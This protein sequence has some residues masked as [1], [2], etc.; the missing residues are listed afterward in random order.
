VGAGIATLVL[1]GVTWWAAT[2]GKGEPVEPSHASP[3]TVEHIGDG[4]FSWVTLTQDAARKIGLEVAEVPRRTEAVTVPYAALVHDAD[5]TT[6]VYASMEEDSLRFR[7]YEVEV[8]AVTGDRAT[9][10]VAPPPGM[11]VA[12]EGSALLY[13]S[14]FEVGH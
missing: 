3:A 14:E 4:E 8:R 11:F 12:G 5:G 9:L 2:S 6:W 7:R 1:F 10:S 13:G